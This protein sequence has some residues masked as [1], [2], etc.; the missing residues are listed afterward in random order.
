MDKAAVIA[1][2]DSL[3]Q[4]GKNRAITVVFDNGINLTLSSDLVIWDD[5][6]ETVVAF[7]ADGH[8]GA[9][10]ADLPIKIICS[11]YENIQFIMSNNNVENLEAVIDSLSSAVVISDENKAKIMEWYTKLY[12][13]RRNLIHK[14]YNPID[15]VRD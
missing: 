12:D 14:N 15:I 13:Y 11:T 5:D 1:I 4:G 7:T 6:K 10:V 9:F 2:R 3:L 8:D